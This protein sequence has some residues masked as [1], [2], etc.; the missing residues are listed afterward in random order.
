MY[1]IVSVS[2]NLRLLINRNDAL[3]VAGYT[4][5]SPRVPRETPLLLQ[6]E[7]ADAVVIGHSISPEERRRLIR[8]IRAAKPG[9]PIVFVYQKPEGTPE[10]HADVSLDVTKGL[11]RLS[12]ISRHG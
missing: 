10:P 9:I 11:R 12:S 4:V 2:N 5:I 1:R 8:A 3:A 6:R 7:G